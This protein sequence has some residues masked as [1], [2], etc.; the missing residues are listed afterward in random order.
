NISRSFASTGPIRDAPPARRRSWAGALALV[1]G[2][3]L[4]CAG[5][6][7]A[8]M[9]ATRSSHSLEPVSNSNQPVNT[10]APDISG[11]PMASNS[12]VT[13]TASDETS[14]AGGAAEKGRTTGSLERGNETAKTAKPSNKDK[15]VSTDDDDSDP[16]DTTVYVGN[17]KIKN[18]RVETPDTI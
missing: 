9:Y 3:L 6:F 13:S 11:N 18:G 2:V 16:Q 14:D 15:Q 5:A 17:M 12:A 8:Y 1:S 7:G 4:L 10:P